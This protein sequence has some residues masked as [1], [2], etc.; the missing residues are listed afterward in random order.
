M[1]LVKISDEVFTAPD[2]HLD[3]DG[4]RVWGGNG[5]VELHRCVFD[6]RNVPAE[7]Q[8]EAVDCIKGAHVYFDGCVFIGCKKAVLCG[9][10]DYP[11]EDHS[12]QCT[13]SNCA[14]LGCGRRCPEVQ[15]GVMAVMY[16]CWVHD[17]GVNH[18][19]VR[20]FG[21]RV[22]ADAT[23]YI[24]DSLFTRSHG[25]G[26][27]NFW[28]DVA[29]Q[30]GECVNESGV[31]YALL[32]PWQALKPGSLRAVDI[33]RSGR[34]RVA[35]WSNVL[36]SRHEYIGDKPDVL[37]VIQSIREA[38]PDMTPFLGMPMDEYFV[39]EVGRPWAR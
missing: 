5:K 19:D 17:W 23:L 1:G 22:S 31:L 6:F 20:T 14:F 15:D 26:F 34:T 2:P 37:G 25:I 28:T 39:R 9:N 21:A 18:F 33:G 38:C 30:I 27:K 24:N 16:K 35:Y 13:F 36:G 12:G 4:L 3:G 10:G 29:N 32:H 11:L 7:E 8:D